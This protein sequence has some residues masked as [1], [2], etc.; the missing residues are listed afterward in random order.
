[1]LH[2]PMPGSEAEMAGSREG[3]GTPGRPLSNV[4]ARKPGP[5]PAVDRHPYR[6]DIVGLL[7]AGWLPRTSNQMPGRRHPDD[8]TFPPNLSDKTGSRGRRPVGGASRFS[9]HRMLCS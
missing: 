9:L 1:M 4:P 3:A 2:E 6:E 7:A 8:P 5:E